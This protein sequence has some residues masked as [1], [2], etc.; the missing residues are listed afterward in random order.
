VNAL[1]IGHYFALGQFS[2]ENF[3]TSVVLLPL[4]VVTNFLGIWLVRVTPTE[5]FYRIAYVLVL[6]VSLVLI[7]QGLFSKP[8]GG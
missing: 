3:M 5:L 6:L 8:L 1:K 4:A 7:W 2:L